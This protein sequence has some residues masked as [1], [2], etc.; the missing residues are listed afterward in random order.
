MSV[1]EDKEFM[2]PNPETAWLEQR[3]TIG[4]FRVWHIIAFCVG[5]LLSIGKLVQ[6]STP[7]P[8]KKK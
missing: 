2:E 8:K 3:T 4:E 1:D 6:I 5:I 7:P